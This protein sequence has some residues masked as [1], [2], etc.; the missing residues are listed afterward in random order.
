MIANE[1]LCCLWN[2][3]Q[4]REKLGE[5]EVQ[6]TTTQGKELTQLGVPRVW[7]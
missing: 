4:L 1:L 7:K 5:N 3:C 6:C 2:H